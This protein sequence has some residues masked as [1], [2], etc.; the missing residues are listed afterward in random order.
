MISMLLGVVVFAG[1]LAY[2]DFKNVDELKEA[3]RTALLRERETES[4]G[5]VKN[6]LLDKLVE[7]HDFP[8]PDVYIDRQVETNVEQQLS[9]LAAQ[10][11]D[12]SKLNLDW[13]KVRDSQ[14]DRAT[15]DVKQDE[16]VPIEAVELDETKLLTRLW[17]EQEKM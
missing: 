5:K 15:R 4:K 13:N 1:L 8:V 16:P 12:V 7:A 6:E 14:K 10:G 11:V 2:G 9:G 3:I 17:R